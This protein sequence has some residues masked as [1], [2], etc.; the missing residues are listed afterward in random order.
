MGK[1][2]IVKNN[3]IDSGIHYHAE[4]SYKKRGKRYYN[5]TNGT[6]DQIEL[7][8]LKDWFEDNGIIL[9]ISYENL[10]S[11]NIQDIFIGSDVSINESD[12]IEYIM[13]IHLTSTCHR[14][15]INSIID[16][17]DLDL[18]SDF[19]EGNYVIMS[20]MESLYQELHERILAGNKELPVS[21][22]LPKEQHKELHEMSVLAQSDEQSIRVYPSGST[23][24]FR[25][26]F[27]RDRERVVNCKAFRRMVDK[28]QIFGS[29]KGDYY[30][31]RMTH[32]LE[33]N[34]IAKA[35]AYALRL[36][37]DLTEAIALGHDLGHTPFGHQGERTLDEILCGK[38]D[39]GI[40]ATAAMF[41]A[42]CYGGFKH[43]YQSARVLTELE[44]KYKEFPGLN[45][46]VQVIEGVLKHTRLK[47]EKIDI[48]DFV[49]EDYLNKM[50]IDK[51][52]EMQVCSSLE[53][54]VVAVAD[55]IAQRGHDVDDAL[56]SGVMT[57]DEFEDRLKI[58]KCEELYGRIFDEIKKVDNS[59]RLIVDSKELKI[60]TIVS[61]IVNYFIETTI[62]YSLGQ[63]RKN[64]Q[65]GKVTLENQI[66]MVGFSPEVKKVN[67]YL[68]KVVQKKVICNSEVARADY[69]AS[70]IVQKLFEKYYKNPRLL[71]SGTIHKIFIETLYH[72]NKE[73]SSSAINLSD[74]GIELVNEEIREITAKDLN[75]EL[76]LDYIRK[77]VNFSRKEEDIIIFEKRKILIR[78]ITDYIAG[79]TDG[80]AMEEYE[81]LK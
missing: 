39:V 33:V 69:N 68:E 30:R 24:E 45:V 12:N 34:Q 6:I 48:R 38:I 28:A 47:P 41:E 49:S 3:N 40:N 46:S 56:T 11:Q 1:V 37:L 77:P 29:E 73:V 19:V 21:D 26:E 72:K 7:S 10:D 14:R 78:A 70:M 22:V 9:M 60:A 16:K 63:I 76:I 52:N 32:S 74:A 23:G 55:E 25:T 59:G 54:Q 53:G 71:H 2:L 43:N 36:N 17:I 79:M 15:T 42:R 62:H 13:K 57:I 51:D 35:I 18:S 66:C 31:T 81:K 27:Q 75:E 4:Q 44:E 64:E 58:S 20:E 61:K 50:Q 5:S 67:D 65:L 80:Y 8:K